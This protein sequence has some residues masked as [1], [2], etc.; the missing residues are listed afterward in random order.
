MISQGSETHR[1]L[2]AGVDRLTAHAADWS[3]ERVLDEGLDLVRDCS[4]ADGSA[5]HAMRDGSVATLCSR[6]TLEDHL[7]DLPVDWF[8]WGLAPVNPRRFIFVGN[9]AA[10]PSSPTSGTSLGDLNVSSCL[11]LPILERQKPIGSLH[12]FWTEPR[13]VWDDESGRILRSLG[14]F[15]LGRA[16]AGASVSS[17]AQDLADPSSSG[18]P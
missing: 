17:A 3:T 5:L 2:S 15:L 18:S 16:A 8:P 7:G 10:L 14:R 1:A 6:P 9:A 4:W 13:L 11:H 12:L